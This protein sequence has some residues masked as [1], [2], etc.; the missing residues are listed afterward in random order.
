[1]FPVGWMHESIYYAGSTK[2]YHYLWQQDFTPWGINDDWRVFRVPKSELTLDGIAE[3]PYASSAKH[4][5]ANM[6]Y[7]AISAERPYR[8]AKRLTMSEKSDKYEREIRS[9]ERKVTVKTETLRDGSTKTS[10]G[11]AQ[12]GGNPSAVASP[13]IPPPP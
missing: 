7:A 11:S 10:I 3:V 13:P 6:R 4:E 5:R 12:T 8:L 2:R 1:M 9:G